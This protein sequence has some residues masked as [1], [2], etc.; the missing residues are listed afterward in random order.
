MKVTMNV[1]C[2]PEEARTFFGLP[3]VQPMQKH[4]LKAM[5]ER[6]STNL[7]AMDPDTMI[8]AWLPA[9]MKGFE[10]LQDIFTSQLS[11]IK[12]R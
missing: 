11:S 8:R 5:Q 3:D 10:Q 12:K 1:D 7:I 2:T 6:L 4:L 9:T